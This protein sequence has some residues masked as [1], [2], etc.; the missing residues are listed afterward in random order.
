MKEV[1]QPVYLDS[2]GNIVSVSKV[3]FPTEYDA[4]EYAM[5]VCKRGQR[6]EIVT[7]EVCEHDTKIASA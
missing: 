6:P 7:L 4:K 5:M 2:A 1:F 3:V